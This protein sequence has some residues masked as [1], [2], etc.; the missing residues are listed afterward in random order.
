M[1][2]A[3]L[4]AGLLAGLARLPQ[5]AGEAGL[6]SAVSGGADSMALALLADRFA[7]RHAQRHNFHH[8]AVIIDHGLR[9]E[10]AGEA[11][12]AS[13]RLASLGIPAE[14]HTLTSP[15]PSSGIQAWAR[16]E[17][18]RL[19]CAIARDRGAVLLTGHHADDQIET[20]SM[21]LQR[22]S[23]L[24][25]LAGIRPL[26]FREGVAV[27]RPLLGVSHDQLVD[28]CHHFD[29]P[30]VCDPSNANRRFERV[31]VRQTIAAMRAARMAVPDQLTRLATAAAVLDDALHAALETAGLCPQIYPAGYADIPAALLT[32]P[33]AVAH[34]LLSQLVGV[35]GNGPTPVSM[36]A[37]SR[38][39]GRMAA[40]KPAT[41][42]GCRFVPGGASGPSGP[43]GPS[44]VAGWT[45]VAEPGRTPPAQRITRD[46]PMIFAGRWRITSP[47]DGVVRFLGSAGSG[48]SRAW[49]EVP[50]WCALASPIR[51]ALPVIETL[52]GD[53][54]YPHLHSVGFSSG[55]VTDRVSDLAAQ[56]P[57]GA[58]ADFLP[59]QTGFWSAP[60]VR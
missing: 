28:L 4:S 23:G 25:G 20:V 7:H 27:L 35:I 18:Y 12:A 45:A 46:R 8:Q 6:I 1:H 33:D 13:A 44:G 51:R 39:V 53:L 16:A 31:R 58:T 50:G 56:Q 29:V 43:S 49:R 22:G 38:L 55:R 59:Y 47:Q 15:P 41:L 2:D 14:I 57:A 54:L 48:A 3:A 11:A 17:R 19:L 32:L 9:P 21:R 36:A 40:G 34:R 24:G 42:G 60:P 37:T 30:F 52:D 10:A 26:S 5:S